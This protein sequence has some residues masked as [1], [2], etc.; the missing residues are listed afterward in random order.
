MQEGGFSA[1][2]VLVHGEERGAPVSIKDR[3]RR[4]QKT[5]I[6]LEIS[7]EEW[8]WIRGCRPERNRK[9]KMGQGRTGGVLCLGCGRPTLA[10]ASTVQERRRG[11]LAAEPWDLEDGQR[12]L[13]SGKG[14]GSEQRALPS[15]RRWSKPSRGRAPGCSPRTSP[16]AAALALGSG[17][18]AD[19]T[20]CPRPGLRREP[21]TARALAPTP[22]PARR[23]RLL[24]PRPRVATGWVAAEPEGRSSL[25]R[26]RGGQP[27]AGAGG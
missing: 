24:P 23:R 12:P 27:M 6:Y 4:D 9:Y 19:G 7:R 13:R 15:G 14:L 26:A 3:E 16:V 20:R 21:G 8:K 1:R 5:A 2:N 11:W 25:G 22:G 18:S 10:G 17:R